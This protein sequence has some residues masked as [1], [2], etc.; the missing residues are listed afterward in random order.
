VTR[1]RG[2]VTDYSPQSKTREL[3]EKIK[4]IIAEY[5]T[6]L[7]IRQIYYRLIARH[8]YDKTHKAYKN[9]VELLAMARRARL[10]DMGAIRDDS[11]TSYYP[12]FFHDADHYI[13]A[14]RRGIENLRLDRQKGQPRRLV[15]MCEA[16]GMAG[17][18]FDI[19]E[20]YGIPVLSGGGFDSVTDK[21]RLA[22]QWSRGKQ[23][24]TVLR[25]G[26]Y[27]ASG[28]SMHMA[29]SE[30]I[31]AFVQ[32]YKGD[33]EFVQV[34]I[35]PDQA[36]ERNLPS[37]P[38]KETDN[39]GA[40]FTDSETWQAEALDPNDLAEILESAILE[41]MDMDAYQAVLDEEEETRQDVISRL[42]L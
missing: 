20:K 11:S 10:I 29:L 6:A 36:R 8:G 21:H 37:A 23:P 9:L 5:P 18:L 19:T 38:P 22:A 1:P 28:Q 42:G 3:I 33:V 13:D 14:V 31:A 15:V 26:D 40:H 41:R 24:I 32:H 2:F 4:A 16:A 30:D 7:T 34:A 39:R 25:I 35:T 12:R 27:D 17:Q